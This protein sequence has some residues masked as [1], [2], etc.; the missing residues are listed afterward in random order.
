MANAVEGRFPFLDHRVVE[1]A[2]AIPPRLKLR[3][4]TE[5]H[6]LR[7]AVRDLLPRRMA[8]RTKQPYRAPDAASFFSGNAP[9]YVDR[10]LTGDAVEAAG[11]F[12][13]GAVDKLIAK[14]RAGRSAG[15]RDNTALTGILSTQL[16]REA[17]AGPFVKT[18]STLSRQRVA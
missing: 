10:V 9:G 14:S 1:Y 11:F 16:W 4:L 2:A 12:D 8:T 15:F 3:G 5:K 6:I 7:E 18:A 13:R 17:F